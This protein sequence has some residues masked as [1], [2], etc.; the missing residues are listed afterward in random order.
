MQPSPKETAFVDNEVL[1]RLP[2]ARLGSTW[3]G[4]HQFQRTLEL[5]PE[6]EASRKALN[7][8]KA[9]STLLFFLSCGF[10]SFFVFPQL[11]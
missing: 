4:L 7:F 6:E 1:N 8:A 5:Y 2:R 11:K 3:F 9:N 10:I